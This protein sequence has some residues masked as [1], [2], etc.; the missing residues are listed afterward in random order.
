M[1]KLLA[2][3]AI[4]SLLAIANL[5]SAQVETQ[6]TDLN[7]EALDAYQ[8]LDIDT[9]T[10]KLQDAIGLAEQNGYVG[11]EVVQSYMN[12][13]VVYAAGVG[14]LDQ[15]LAAF[16]NAICMQPDAQLDPLL[17]T[18]DVQQVFMQAQADAQ[19]GACPGGVPA[20]A[21]APGPTGYPAQQ[22]YPQQQYPQQ[23]MDGSQALDNECPPGIKCDPTGEGGDDSPT[24]FARWFIN[25]QVVMGMALV[26]SGM[27]AD[28]RPEDA[29]EEIFIRELVTV[30][31]P[32]TGMEVQEER[33]FFDDRSAWVPDAD[34]FDDFEQADLDIPRG[35]TPVSTKCAAD[36]QESGPLTLIDLSTNQ[37]QFDTDQPS[38]YCVRVETPGVVTA[39]AL[40]L[41]PGYWIT[42]TFALSLPFR[43]QFD[44]GQGTLSNMLI[45]LR[46][47]L[48][49]SKMEEA[50][51]FPISWF[52]GV[53]YGQIQAKPPP[54][55]PAR[56]APYVISGPFG[57]HTGFNFRFRI[58][59]NFGLVL[60][61][62]LDVQ[63]PDFLINVDVGGGLEA[64]F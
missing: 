32:V 18:P 56:P 16:L 17:S 60:G 39:L 21:P 47:E 42:D 22:Q 25:A 23:P 30:T 34:S 59:R 8:N 2:V 5:A 58:H 38:R 13:G 6:I 62:E 15:G 31:D 35:V 50:T 40:R 36:G 51:G 20:A 1:K 4:T 28:S 3:G 64:A 9:A 55:D 63:F 29:G 24:D 54:K 46:G 11:P 12:L 7:A 48:M 37:F 33:I 10:A 27:E 14:D 43:L 61:P 53:T 45:G 26:Q 52:F 49:F 19:A 44:A 57:G 41:N